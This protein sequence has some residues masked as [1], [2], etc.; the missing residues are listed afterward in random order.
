MSAITANFV[1]AIRRTD[2]TII[3]RAVRTMPLNLKIG[4]III[5]TIALL[6]IL[7][8][9]ISP[10]DPIRGDFRNTLQPPS[11][12]HPFGTDNVGRDLFSRVLHGASID[13]QIGLIT[14]YVP[15]VYGIALGAIAGYVGGWFDLLL[16]RLVDFAIAFP[17]LVL[18]IVI[19]AV[20]GPG[21]QNMYI[22]VFAVAWTMYARLARAEML[23]IREQEYILAARALGYSR[24]RIIFRHALPNLIAPSI[25]FSMADIVLNILLAASLSFFGMGVQP[26]TP[27][28]GAIVA[29]GRDWLLQ[30]WWISTLPGLA[31]V[32]TGL[33]FSLI[34]DGLAK[35]LGQRNTHSPG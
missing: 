34:G 35:M 16:M 1:N 32:L 4:L 2:T 8:P 12:A 23:V 3:W 31:I 26:P 9:V 18:I 10:Y 33:G 19:L 20:L 6:G 27:E 14:T 15:F 21:I 22:A 30:A 17:F 5:G 24:W 11:L 28:W 25:V 13:L 7:A 29:D